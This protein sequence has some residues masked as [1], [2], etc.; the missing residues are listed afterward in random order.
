VPGGATGGGG[1][2]IVG[3]VPGKSVTCAWCGLPAFSVLDD[4][5]LV[6]VERAAPFPPPGLTVRVELPAGFWL[7]RAPASK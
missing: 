7:H 2:G 3:G 4:A 6:A 5:A 1:G